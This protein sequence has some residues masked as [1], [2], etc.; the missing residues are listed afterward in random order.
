MRTT[1][2]QGPHRL[3]ESPFLR[4][5]RDPS[6]AYGALRW[7]LFP[8][9]DAA[10]RVDLAPA[11]HVVLGRL[12]GCASSAILPARPDPGAALTFTT[13]DPICVPLPEALAGRRRFSPRL[14]RRVWADVARAVDALHARG[15]V[16]G[17][18]DPARVLLTTTGVVLPDAGWLTFFRSAHGGVLGPAS[19]DWLLLVPE[20]RLATAEML[21]QVAPTP[22]G[23]RALLATL[24]AW[25][26]NPIAPFPGGSALAW[27]AKVQ[28]GQRW[29]VLGRDL[30]LERVLAL[31]DDPAVPLPE[32]VAALPDADAALPDE[33]TE[34]VRP[35][36]H[37]LEARTALVNALGPI[38]PGRVDV[39]AFLG[40]HAPRRRG[41][42]VVLNALWILLTLGLGLVVIA[43][44]AK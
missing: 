18:I 7:E 35:W 1:G 26:S 37:R 22:A 41:R 16:L 42:R 5:S 17:A 19:S 14:A 31:L 8:W 6:E 24:L 44:I 9:R 25:L 36:S 33:L 15:L 40:P 13:P 32:V 4:V 38:D 43:V 28:A 11:F 20:P 10:A 27:F 29:P 34:R 23:D 39:S 30:E 21:S 2:P 12:A 3:L